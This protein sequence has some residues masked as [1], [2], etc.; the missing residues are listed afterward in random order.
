MKAGYE[1]RTGSP[2]PPS[3]AQSPIASAVDSSG[4]RAASWERGTAILRPCQRISMSMSAEQAPYAA[5][6]QCLPCG[7]AR[8]L[9]EDALGLEGESDFVVEIVI[10][11]HRLLFWPVSVHDGLVVD[12]VFPDRILLRFFHGFA[13]RMRHTEVRPRCRTDMS[14][15]ITAHERSSMRRRAASTGDYAGSEDVSDD[16]CAN[17]SAAMCHS[18]R[19]AIIGST[20]AALRAGT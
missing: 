3:N 4:L 18:Y 19:S 10:P 13:A 5:L 6:R 17:V 11:A 15:A 9:W 8:P 2:A 7:A 14:T 16:H 20:R 1:L 12:A